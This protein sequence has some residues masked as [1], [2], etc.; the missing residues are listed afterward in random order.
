MGWRL[1][2]GDGIRKLIRGKRQSED[3]GDGQQTQDG[4]DQGRDLEKK[5]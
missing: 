2:N 5:L 4:K 1:L 3:D